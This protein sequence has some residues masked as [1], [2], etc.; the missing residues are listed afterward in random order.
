[1]AK[2]CSACGATL[3]DEMIFCNK[4]GAR[5]REGAF[6]QTQTATPVQP[7]YNTVAAP[8]PKAKLSVM[9]FA[10]IILCI[11]STVLF[12]ATPIVEISAGDYTES[13]SIFYFFENSTV[14]QV[15]E[16]A[17][18]DDDLGT[19]QYITYGAVAA[20][21]VSVLMLIVAMVSKSSLGFV[22]IIAQTLLLGIGALLVFVLLK[23]P[24]NDIVEV[25]VSFGL[26]TWGW[27][28]LC[29][30]SFSIVTAIKAIQSKK[31]LST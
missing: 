11:V 2:V 9:W 22:S 27:V 28:F 8:K 6:A 3:S 29:A 17:G 13:H 23:G 25:E 1:M 18:V 14:Q 24:V 31:S 15:A 10:A 21:A 5:Y 26:T 4:C 20:G 12:V 19:A 30:G 7:V 16:S